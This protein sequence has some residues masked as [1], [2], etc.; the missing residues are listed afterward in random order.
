[1]VPTSKKIIFRQQPQI[2]ISEIKANQPCSLG[3]LKP[4]GAAVFNLGTPGYQGFRRGAWDGD[5]GGWQYENDVCLS[6]FFWDSWRKLEWRSNYYFFWNRKPFGVPNGS[7]FPLFRQQSSSEQIA[8][9]WRNSQYTWTGWT[10]D[11][12]FGQKV[13]T[14]REVRD[15][16]AMEESLIAEQWKMSTNRR[17]QNI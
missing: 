14:L 6:M 3:Q 13:A 10:D 7:C 5:E 12:K 17:S 15:I 11:R 1:M 16:L 9:E 2:F 4:T 8:E